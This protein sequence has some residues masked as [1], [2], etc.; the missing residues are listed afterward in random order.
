MSEHMMTVDGVN[1]WRRADGTLVPESLLKP[2]DI[3]RDKLVRALHSRFVDHAEFGRKLR[4]DAIQAVNDFVTLEGYGSDHE[5]KGAS[6]QLSTVDGSLRL[7][8]ERAD[9]VTVNEKL[10]IAQEMIGEYLDS[11][12]ADAMTEVRQIVD[13]AFRPKRNGRVAVS[14]LLGL[15]SLKIEHPKWRAAM[16]ALGEALQADSS[17]EYVRVHER[18]A[19]GRYAHVSLHPGGSE[20]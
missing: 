9:L 4:D 1:Y 15:R 17:V 20:A 11:I 19:D 2:V 10:A 18:R 8:K 5:Y 13:H 3:E 14:K 16:D 6:V 12:T 7:T